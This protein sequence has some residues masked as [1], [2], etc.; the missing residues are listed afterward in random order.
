MTPYIS[1]DDHAFAGNQLRII[2]AFAQLGQPWH[3]T[4]VTSV[5]LLSVGKRLFGWL[6]VSVELRES[7]KSW[8]VLTLALIRTKWFSKSM[9][10]MLRRCCGCYSSALQSRLSCLSH[11]IGRWDPSARRSLR[12]KLCNL[13]LFIYR[14]PSDHTHPSQSLVLW[15]FLLRFSSL[16]S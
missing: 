16:P 5:A 7:S 1:L 13:L 11:H 12:M 6:V 10:A 14:A 3:L 4:Q 15:P 2:L 8:A 9:I